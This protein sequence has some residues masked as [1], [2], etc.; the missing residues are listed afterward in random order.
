M[1]DSPN[2][3]RRLRRLLGS[4]LN[5][6]WA[7]VVVIV[8]VLGYL[9]ILQ[10]C[11]SANEVSK[12]GVDTARAVGDAAAAV[13]KGLHSGNVTTRFVA[14]IPHL[15]PQ[16]SVRLELAAFEATETIARSDERL[17]LW[18][19]FSLGTNV[20]EIRV[21]VTYR[22]HL[23]MGDPW[24]LTIRDGICTVQAPQIRPTLPP[25]IHTD[26]MEKNSQRGW[27]RWD[28]DDQMEELERSV[29]PTLILR[30]KNDDHLT[31]VRE[32]CRSNVAEFVRAWLLREDHW[33]RDRLTAIVVRFADEEEI[34]APNLPT[35]TLENLD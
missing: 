10:F 26:R 34:N 25:A 28:A 14:A 24:H 8:A 30:A 11:R 7:I 20:T 22:Y 19:K 1:P 17:V 27:G 3:G 21:P 29:T 6:R 32:E 12:S 23:E 18:D 35:L 4:L 31:M 13:A 16:D 33:R 15:L 9:S 5:A 2:S